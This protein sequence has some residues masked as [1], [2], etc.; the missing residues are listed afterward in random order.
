VL[1]TAGVIA[2]KTLAA[3]VALRAAHLPWGAAFGMGLGLSQLGEFGFI[4]LSEALRAGAIPAGVYDGMLAIALTTLLLTPQMV[5]WGLALARREPAPDALP[6][7][8]KGGESGTAR[9][10]VIG[11]GPIGRTTA[12][13]LET[14]GFEVT[15]V[16]RSPLNLHGFAQ[17]GFY[18][19]TGDALESDVL[20]RAGV[21]E[22]EVVMVAVPDDAVAARIT[23]R[24][25]ALTPHAV[26]VV[27]CR[28][29]RNAGA[30]RDAGAAL[31][32]SEE[33][34]AVRALGDVLA[35]FR[36]R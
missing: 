17:L 24:V 25:R 11:A 32:V 29:Q 31:V 35:R 15:L 2:V 14:R 7:R 13:G 30:L 1:G 12:S 23:A 9:A 19:V 3:A 6:A 27:R 8:P 36:P 10:V 33:S 28:Y 16:D 21:P 18:T 5:R 4:V 34:E 26:I 20:E 22:A